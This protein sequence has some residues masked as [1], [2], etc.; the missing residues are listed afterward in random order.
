MDLRGA[1][2][3]PPSQTEISIEDYI[4]NLDLSGVPDYGAK[5]SPS[6]PIAVPISYTPIT[7]EYKQ[8][9]AIERARIRE[10]QAAQSSQV[11]HTDTA[12]LE[13]GELG[14]P[15]GLRSNPQR[16]FKPTG[17]MEALFYDSSGMVMACGPAGT[18]KS[19]AFL[20]KIHLLCETSACRCLMVRSTR[21]A[22]S[23]TGM[24]TFETQ[25]LPEGH[26]LLDGN[27]R[28]HRQSYQYKTGA[29]FVMGGLDNM[30]K[31]MSSEFDIIYIQE[32]LDLTKSNLEQLSTRLRNAV[33]PIQQMLMC[34]NPGDPNH[35]LLQAVRD[36]RISLH[37]TYHEDNPTL[38]EE[39]PTRVIEELAKLKRL[40]MAE[41]ELGKAW[42]EKSRDGR[43]GRWTEAGVNYIAKLDMLTGARYKRLRLGLWVA[44]EGAVYEDS[45][46]EKA[47]ICEPFDPPAEWRRI[48]VVDFGFT[49]PFVLYKVAIDGDLRIYVYE[50]VYKTR[51]TVEIHAVK[52]LE[53]SGWV[54]SQST[55]HRAIRRNPD[56]L[57]DYI[58]CD[59]DAEGRQTLEDYT[60]IRTVPAYKGANKG[61]SSGIQAVEKRL[62]IRADGKSGIQYMRN[63]LV[64]RD[65]SLRSGEHAVPQC[66][67]EEYAGYVWDVPNKV[68]TNRGERPLQVN[69]HGMDTTRYLVCNIDNITDSI[70]A[71]DVPTSYWVD[72]PYVGM[73]ASVPRSF[74]SSR[75]VNEH[76]RSTGE[77]GAQRESERSR[78]IASKHSSVNKA[79]SKTRS[80]SLKDE[81]RLKTGW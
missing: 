69:D 52:A 9:A 15:E 54:W 8:Q 20:E 36:G 31:F 58:V 2:G 53:R 27:K 55:G 60:G 48:W 17:A 71:D 1:V 33:L 56:P 75:G 10:A 80:L 70:E 34:V 43:R 12:E 66:T 30:L 46:D 5:D 29:Q 72:N 47:A 63:C 26:Y 41:G 67:V 79:R 7:D 61:I 73:I 21:E 59:W 35:W 40:G 77:Y 50:E 39:A 19:R 32:A 68:S 78:A 24:Y 74:S 49:A 18:G 81:H 13:H 44:A 25:V 37:D 57:P 6:E 76:N 64:E 42:P 28:T 45:W 3:L 23:E 16:P 22:L 4:N 62:M 51:V 38:W 65:T 11:V 14:K